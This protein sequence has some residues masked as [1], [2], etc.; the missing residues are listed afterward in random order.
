MFAI[1][2][3]GYV[4]LHPN[5]K[6]QVSP[7]GG[8]EGAGPYAVGTPDSL[9]CLSQSNFR[10]PVTLDFLDAE[11]EDENK[12]EVR[13]EGRGRG[14]WS[15]GGWGATLTSLALP[16]PTEHDR[17]RQGPQAGQNAGQVPGRG[18]KAVEEGQSQ[19]GRCP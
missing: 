12:E 19:G 17:R 11:L 9:P 6:P 7:G 10:E 16:D 15:R 3:N 13:K 1:D 18:E 14:A 4:L 5:L 2:L 8:L